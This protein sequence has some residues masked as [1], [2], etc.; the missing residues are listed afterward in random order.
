MSDQPV[1]RQA[2]IG[3]L[4]V[5]KEIINNSFPW[6]FRYFATESVSDLSEPTLVLEVQGTVKAF[7]KQI[8]F[9]I[10]ETKYGCILWIAVDANYRRQGLAL[11]LTN[12]S[13][14]WQKKNGA[15]TVFASTQRSNKAALATLKKAGFVRMGF[16]EIRRLFGWRMLQ[17]FGDIWLAP[18]EVV[19]AHFKT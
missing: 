11:E 12:A 4:P 9:K 17:F 1:I 10:K 3:D 19:L 18:G 16:S 14:E 5:L 8:E 7:A 2:N 15:Q 6:F 13:L